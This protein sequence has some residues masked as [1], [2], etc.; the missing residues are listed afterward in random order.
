LNQSLFEIQAEFCK[1]MGNTAR[2]QLLHILRDNPLTVT[3]ICQETGLPQGTVSRQLTVL[4]R[5]GVVVSLRHGSTKIY[6]L[7]DHK[8][9]EVCDLVRTILVEQIH[10]RSQSIE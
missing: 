9:A 1:A 8:I 10:K 5:V 3:E 7:T 2:L 6:A 4:R